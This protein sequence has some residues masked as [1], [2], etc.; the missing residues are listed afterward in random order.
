MV[1][2]NKVE[3]AM[4]SKVLLLEGIRQQGPLGIRIQG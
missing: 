3:W 2:W 4:R 1:D